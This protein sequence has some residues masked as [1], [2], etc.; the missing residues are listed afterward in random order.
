[1]TAVRAVEYYSDLDARIYPWK[2]GSDGRG[3]VF[4]EGLRCIFDK[5]YFLKVYSYFSKGW[6]VKTTILDLEAWWE[7]L[8]YI[9]FKD[10]LICVLL[11]PF[12]SL[13]PDNIDKTVLQ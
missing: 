8:I 7:V 4:I 11:V 6:L 12:A 9:N 3:R 5:S 1:M 10:T 13:T 2:T